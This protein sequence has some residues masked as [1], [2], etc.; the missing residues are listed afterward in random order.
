MGDTVNTASRMESLCK[1]LGVDS[2]LSADLARE[3]G[4][5]VPVRALGDATVKGKA[6]PIPVFTLA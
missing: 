6:R 4:D 5:T 3:L 1:E 2:V